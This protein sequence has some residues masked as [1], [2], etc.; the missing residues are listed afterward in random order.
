MTNLK[1]DVAVIGAGIGG[2]V[3]AIRC[4]QL[5]KSV[6]LFEKDIVGG[7]CANRGCIP[8]KT[9][10][11]TAS[12]LNKIFNAAELGV[13]IRKT[14]IDFEKIM[15]R[16]DAVVTRLVQGVEYLIKKNKVTLI[17]GK[18][19]F[20]SENQILVE[21][22]TGEEEIFTAEHIIVASG[23][24]E[25]KPSYT[26][27]DEEKILTSRGALNL[28]ECPKSLAV[29]GGGVFGVEFASFFKML[30]T[31]V[32]IFESSQNLLPTFDVDISRNYERILRKKA[33]EIYTKA[34]V[35]SVKTGANG[36][37]IIEAKIEGQEIN[38]ETE[39]ALIMD[40]RP[41][42]STKLGL[43]KVGVELKNGFIVVDN[44]QRTNILNI[45]A[46]GDVTGNMMLAH[47]AYAEGIVAAENIL[48]YETIMD[49]K[50]VPVCVYGEP[51]IASVGFS[52]DEAKR[53]GYEVVYGKFPLQAS[54]RAIT[55]GETEGFA[56]VVCDRE[57][58]EILGVHLI[59]PRVTELIGEATLAIK[60]EC[61]F[62]E[63]GNL[64][65]PHP[66]ISE[67]L[68][69]AAKAVANKAIHV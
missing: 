34:S 51:E 64:I 3:S 55:F 46:V 16:K 27:V 36:K 67:A 41:P 28:R 56:K 32:K 65:H 31:N 30:G 9:L 69:E 48:G 26:V 23:S 35:K 47:A 53:Q 19:S 63:I 7:T 37:V 61:T 66:T 21:K 15:A 11:A 33:I 58:G 44:H 50:T 68:M 39:K 43:E 13:N 8:T 24:E 62:E 29:I 49:H 1:Y 2:Y 14:E 20:I 25:P 57:T 17:K 42:V 38:V 5:G 60:L 54:G 12:L 40:A 6:V 52:E 4:A 59:G 45:Y 22:S 10:L 18:A